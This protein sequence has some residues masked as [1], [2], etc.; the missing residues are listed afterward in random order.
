MGALKTIIGAVS[1]SVVAALDAAGYPPLTPDQ[2]GNAGKILVGTAALFEQVSAPRIIF[3]PL[4]SKF[5]GAE[6]SSAS[7]ALN[8]LE[9]RHQNAMRTVAAEDVM[10]AVRV[11]GAAGTGDPVD[12]YDVTR[13]LYHQIRASMQS[14]MPG[15]FAIDDT[16]KYTVGS[17]VVLS[18]R[19]FVFG[20]TIFT[21]ILNALMPYD[22]VNYTSAQIATATARLYA[23]A[24]VTY[25]GT[26]RMISSDGTVGAAEPGCD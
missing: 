25:E 13:A 26:D 23:P 5:G 7:A 6:Y 3:E 10:F 14:V 21:P 1:D 17:N 20:V 24:G 4:G 15:A 19:E 9:R 2:S 22:L 11:W 16:G 12:D 8:T 18:G